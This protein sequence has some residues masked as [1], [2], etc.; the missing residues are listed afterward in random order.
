MIDTETL[1]SV[2]TARSS[3]DMSREVTQELLRRRTLA[4]AVPTFETA[5]FLSPPRDRT[6]SWDES[7]RMSYLGFST[8]SYYPGE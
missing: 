1:A 8:G 2:Q 6:L 7:P 3:A 5:A 4:P